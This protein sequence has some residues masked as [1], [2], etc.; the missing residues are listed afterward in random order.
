MVWAVRVWSRCST[1]PLSGRPR[2]SEG[3]E[4]SLRAFIFCFPPGFP[5]SPGDPVI[6]RGLRHDGRESEL[7]AIPRLLS[8]RPRYSEGIETI[9]INRKNTIFLFLTYPT[10]PVIQRGLRRGRLFG[11]FVANN[12]KTIQQTPLFRGD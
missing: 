12:Q 9:Q 5:A 10:D 4:T 2:Y 7:I 6:Q 11:Q 1:E 3:I 8:G